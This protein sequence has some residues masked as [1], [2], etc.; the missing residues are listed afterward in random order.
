MTFDSNDTLFKHNEYRLILLMGPLGSGKAELARRTLA[1]RSD[2][3]W[4]PSS[5]YKRDTPS[6]PDSD[7]VNVVVMSN[8]QG[9]WDKE[10][11]RQTLA[12]CKRHNKVALILLG[13]NEERDRLQLSVMNAFLVIHTSKAHSHVVMS[14]GG[15]SL[16][17]PLLFADE[18]IQAD[19]ALA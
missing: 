13:G 4:A 17:V 12:W 1:H 6:L 11:V 8:P 16:T 2:V 5:F 15:H 14:R 3:F 19:P 9:T 18:G 7:R 10:V